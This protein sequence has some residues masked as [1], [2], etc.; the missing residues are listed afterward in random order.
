MIV[1]ER[2]PIKELLAMIEGYN[3]ILMVGC[4]GCVTVCNAGGKKEV[5]ILAAAL[6]IARAKQ[7]KPVTID[8]LT[9]DRQCEPEFIMWL[10]DPIKK[11]NYDAIISLACSIGPQYIAETFD[12]M[13]VFPGLNTTFMGG[14]VEHGIWGEYCAACG[15]CGIHNFGGLCPITRCAKSLLNGPCG[16]SVNGKC[17]VSDDMDCVW[18]LI[19]ER[20][21]KLGQLDRLAKTIGAKDWSTS[22]S[23]GPRKIIREDLTL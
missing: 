10:D 22:L 21:K 5:A 19:Y 2:K 12:T 8:E 18:K 4:K 1:G 9:L 20:K 3:K 13:V 23:G 17:E 14:T 16:G 6:R 7:G 11:N 15:N